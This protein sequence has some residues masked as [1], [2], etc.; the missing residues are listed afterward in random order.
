M[1]PLSW[2]LTPCPRRYTHS[3]GESVSSKPNDQ[4]RNPCHRADNTQARHKHWKCQ[5]Q[6][7]VTLP[8]DAVQT[9]ELQAWVTHC[10]LCQS[11]I[12]R[13]TRGRTNHRQTS[14]RICLLLL[15]SYL[16]TP[17]AMLCYHAKVGMNQPGGCLTT[18]LLY[19]EISGVN[20]V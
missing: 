6:P 16:N 2:F 12:Y 14:D 17:L 19:R 11:S 8:R 7:V 10:N 4:R 3:P 9:S 13:R 1:M 18:C 15:L 5:A 20:R